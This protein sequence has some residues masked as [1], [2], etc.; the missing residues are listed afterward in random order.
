MAHK[1]ASMN[2]DDA[3]AV[4]AVAREFSARLIPYT[5][6]FHFGLMNGLA[7]RESTAPVIC[8]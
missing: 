8:P 5:G 2:A 1:S 4:G 7:V 3:A 6:A